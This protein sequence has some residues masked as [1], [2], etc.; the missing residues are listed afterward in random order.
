[1]VRDE[2]SRK[3]I[4]I[5]FSNLFYSLPLQILPRL[6]HLFITRLHIPSLLYSF[7]LLFSL[8]SL[9]PFF[10]FLSLCISSS[11]HSFFFNDFSIFLLLTAYTILLI[12]S[13]HPPFFFLFPLVYILFSLFYNKR[14]Y[15]SLF[16]FLS[17]S[18]SYFLISSLPF[19]ILHLSHSFMFSL[20]PS[21]GP[22]YTINRREKNTRIGKELFFSK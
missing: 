20:S 13:L 17:H 14:F 4:R 5:I 3:K 10:S 11:P 1:M 15:L 21:F 22:F 6:S 18:C 9:Y 2:R 7:P 19:I 8:F 16:V 12:S